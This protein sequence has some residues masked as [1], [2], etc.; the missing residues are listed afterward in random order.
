MTA[1]TP[2]SSH[3]TRR[4]AVVWFPLSRIGF[5]GSL[6]VQGRSLGRRVD[7][8]NRLGSSNLPSSAPS[9]RPFAATAGS[10]LRPFGMMSGNTRFTVNCYC[11]FAEESH[12][13]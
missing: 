2:D 5:S 8:L 12:A 1:P 11:R 10:G 3:E 9:P 6:P 7:G 13:P 4:L